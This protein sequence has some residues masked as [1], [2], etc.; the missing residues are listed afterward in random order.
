MGKLVDLVGQR[1]NRLTVL[2][3][4]EKNLYGKP[5]WICRCDCGKNTVVG[6]YQLKSGHIKSCGCLNNESDLKAKQ[7][8]GSRFGRL[9]VVVR[10]GSDKH[11]Q[12]LWKCVCDCGNETVVTSRKLLTGN[13]KSCG[14]LVSPK[15][16][17]GVRFGRLTVI[18]QALSRRSQDS[19]PVV[20]WKCRCDCGAITE[21]DGHSLLR[22]DTRSCGCYKNDIHTTHGKRGTRLYRIWHGMKQRCLNPK[23][24][25]FKHYGGRGIVICDEWLNDFSA[26]YEWAMANGYADDLTIDRVDVNGSYEPSNCRWA[27][28]KEQAS[29]RRPSA[30]KGG[31]LDG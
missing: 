19:A 14:C 30:A 6:G 2:G 18:E 3:R 5:A 17:V 7:L 25:H 27:T 24:T 26:F 23:H 9:T 21:V 31:V 20:R 28:A 16:L 29:N 4:S 22:G 11:K 1:F 12:A 15:S 10:T 13:T 8:V